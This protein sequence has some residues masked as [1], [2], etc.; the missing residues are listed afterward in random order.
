MGHEKEKYKIFKNADLFINASLFEGLP[1]A[2]VQ[3]INYNVYPICSNAPG[4][5]IEVINNGKFGMSFDLNDKNDLKKKII[6]FI[7]KKPKL[8]NFA[9]I[10]HLKKY[11][12]ENSNKKYLKILNKV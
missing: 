9:R 4:G 6:R 10:K 11:T 2:L 7:N 12:E 3:A 8:N 1:N 5:N